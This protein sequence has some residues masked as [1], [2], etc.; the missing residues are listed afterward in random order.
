[1]NPLDVNVITRIARPRPPP[2]PE[3][4]PPGGGF[5]AKAT[6]ATADVNPRM[7]IKRERLMAGSYRYNEGCVF[8]H[9]S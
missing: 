3:G 5:C 7:S 8:R 6:D 4:A 1:V 9:A 2:R